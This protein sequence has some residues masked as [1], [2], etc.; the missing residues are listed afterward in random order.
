MN[1]PA[2]MSKKNESLKNARKQTKKKFQEKNLEKLIY[3]T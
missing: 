1:N 2:G 3:K